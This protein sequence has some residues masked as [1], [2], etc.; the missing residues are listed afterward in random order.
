MKVSEYML[1]LLING[2]IES[3]QRRDT[4]SEKEVLKVLL[5]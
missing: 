4:F 2:K 1:I 5:H 3:C